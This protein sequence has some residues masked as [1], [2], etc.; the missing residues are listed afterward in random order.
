MIKL[1]QIITSILNE[2]TDNFIEFKIYNEYYHGDSVPDIRCN[3]SGLFFITP[4][5]E[6]AKCYGEIVFKIKLLTNNIFNPFDE[7]HY[8]LIGED[9]DNY[10]ALRLWDS[11]YLENSFYLEKIKNAKFDGFFVCDVGGISSS[12]SSANIGLFGLNTVKNLG[13][14][15]N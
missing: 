15:K 4:D 10:Q 12:R 11:S 2:N 6:E 5:Y 13:Q 14:V 1:K 3:R 8:D 9:Y 7:E